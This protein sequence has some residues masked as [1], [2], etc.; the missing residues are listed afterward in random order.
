MR[1]AAV[2][3]AVMRTGLSLEGRREG[4]VRDTY[5]ARLVDGREAVVLVA[6]DRLSAFDV[7]MPTG[8]PGK[9]VLLTAMASWWFERIGSAAGVLDGLG[10]HVLGTDAGVI[11]GLSAAERGLLKGRVTL[12]RPCDVV[13]IECVVRGYLAGSGW[14]EYAAS[15]AVCGV[16]LASGLRESERLAEPIFTPA[17]KAEAGHDENVSFD[18]ACELVGGELMERL[19]GWSLRLY[20]MGAE[21]AAE[22]G[23]ILADTKFE[24]GV[25]VDGGGAV[26]PI[27]ID[28]A[29]TMDSSRY[30][31]AEGYEAGRAQPSFDKQ[32]VRDWLQGL[33]DAGRWDKR[34]PGPELP[35][36]VVAGVL[37]RYREGWRR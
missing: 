12:G 35:G 5:R 29:L 22:R 34:A 23:L 10:H 27:L 8:V 20:A 1:G 26:E 11:E 19:R 25:P 28:E 9:G 33:C 3:E 30:W 37:E 2:G 36:E 4:K 32:Y 17:T 13:P 14:K 7:V 24:F 6:T 18:R 31:P 16:K 21:R 15:G